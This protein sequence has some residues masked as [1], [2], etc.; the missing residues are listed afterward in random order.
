MRKK[1]PTGAPGSFCDEWEEG[2][3]RERGVAAIGLVA[4]SRPYS[5]R[6]GIHTFSSEMKLV[7]ERPK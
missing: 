3:R 4:A 7:R 1:E 6:G 2:R 5:N